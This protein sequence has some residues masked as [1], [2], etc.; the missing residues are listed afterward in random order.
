MRGDGLPL[1]VQLQTAHGLPRPGHNSLN[2]LRAVAVIFGREQGDGV[3]ADELPGRVIEHNAVVTAGRGG[4]G[5]GGQVVDGGQG[6]LAG[7]AHRGPHQE[8]VGWPGRVGRA[9]GQLVLVE[10]GVGVVGHPLR[11]AVAHD[12]FGRVGVPQLCL[13]GVQA[14]LADAGVGI[15]VIGVDP[16]RV[17]AG[18]VVA[19]KIVANLMRG[20]RAGVLVG[21]VGAGG[22]FQAGGHPLPANPGVAGKAAAKPGAAVVGDGDE[23]VVD[24]PGRGAI[25]VFERCQLVQQPLPFAALAEVAGEIVGGAKGDVDLAKRVAAHDPIADGVAGGAGVELAVGGVGVVDGHDFQVEGRHVVEEQAGGLAVVA[26]VKFGHAVAAVYGDGEIDAAVEPGCGQQGVDGAG[27]VGGLRIERDAERPQDERGA[28]QGAAPLAGVNAEGDVPGRGG[29]HC[30]GKDAQEG[31]AAAHQGHVV[32]RRLHGLGQLQAGDGQVYFGQGGLVDERQEDG[33]VGRFCRLALDLV[34]GAVADVAHVQF[35]VQVFAKGD[36]AE[37]DQVVVAGGDPTALAV[38]G[39]VP[40]VAE[41]VVGGQVAAAEG[42][43]LAATIHKAAGDGAAVV[44]VVVFKDGA[45]VVPGRAAVG[46]AG[47]GVGVVAFVA[48]PAIILAAGRRGRLK[49]DL[50]P[51]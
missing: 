46:H 44:G 11:A 7:I 12:I 47:V 49:I 22:E 27:Q 6:S 33:I 9:V 45:D 25:P 5:I 43:E 24:L 38:G 17:A 39:Q 29:S 37:V 21:P 31:V 4:G 50:L 40:E 15:G 51:G 28:G 35:T 18:R 16:G 2:G 20:Q 10:G 13:A 1:V 48:A 14:K 32:G 23:A 36:V 3:T 19:A 26:F 30:L 8:A 42:G 41:A 34:D